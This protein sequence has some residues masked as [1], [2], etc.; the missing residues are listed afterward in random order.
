MSLAAAKDDGALLKN[1]VPLNALSDEQLGPLLS[2]ISVERAKKGTFLF[3]AG[4]RDEQNIYILSGHVTF[5]S[6]GREVD[7]VRSDSETARYPLAHK[8]PRQLSARAKTAVTFVR[9]DSRMLSDLL[10]R[11]QADEREL[12]D[13]DS[14]SGDWMSQLLQSPIFQQIPPAN[15]QQVMMRMETIEASAGDVIIRQNDKGDYYY[16]ISRGTCIVTRQP[17]QNSTPV[18]LAQLGPGNSFGEE[19][20]VSQMP[21]S[22]T[23]TMQTDGELVRLGKE[24]FENLVCTPLSRPLKYKEALERIEAGARWIDI[25]LPEEYE[26]L[27]LDEAIN[28]PSFSLR[29]QT[30]NLASNLEYIVYSKKPSFAAATAFLLLE[31][32]FSVYYLDEMLSKFLKKPSVTNIETPSVDKNGV[33]RPESTQKSVNEEYKKRL[34]QEQI[35]LQQ[36][37]KLLLKT[38]QS[39]A[40]AAD[41]KSKVT[42]QL[43][44][45]KSELEQAQS[46][47]TV[48][49]AVADERDQAV[50][51]IETLHASREAAEKSYLQQEGKLKEQIT[52][53]QLELDEAGEAN[54]TQLS[55]SAAAKKSIAKLEQQ[56]EQAQQSLQ[57]GKEQQKEQIATLQQQLA[58]LSDAGADLDSE[59][60]LQ[61]KHIEQLTHELASFREKQRADSA[62]QKQQQEQQKSESEQ[63]E[64]AYEEL[65]LKRDKLE[66]EAQKQNQHIELLEQQIEHSAAANT[67]FDEEKIELQQLIT[68]L[69]DE[70]CKLTE[71]HEQ[72]NSAHQNA[73]AESQHQTDSTNDELQKRS[74]Q[75]NEMESGFSQ[76][77]QQ[78]ERLNSTGASQDD[79][80]NALQTQT[81]TLSSELERLQDQLKSEESARLDEQAAHQE[82]L[83]QL[84]SKLQLEQDSTATLDQLKDSFKTEKTALDQQIKT[85]QQQL[86]DVSSVEAHHDLERDEQQQCISALNDKLADHLNQIEALEDKLK[87]AAEEQDNSLHAFQET[88]DE[89]VEKKDTFKADSKQLEQQLKQLTTEHNE[90]SRVVQELTRQLEKQGTE[91][92]QQ[93]TSSL[94]L[95]QRVDEL[96]VNEQLLLASLQDELKQSQCEIESISTERDA[97][98]QKADTAQGEVQQLRSVMEQYVDQIKSAQAGGDNA[99]ELE[100]LQ[101]ELETVRIQA[102]HDLKKLALRRT[103]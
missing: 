8:F 96:E 47:L 100:A 67:G 23:V 19:S 41:E 93:Q 18:K 95:Q 103:V 11:T 65:E 5:I 91:S 79:E 71:Q 53:L 36:L 68:S 27:H 61:Q 82:Q 54:N 30:F 49:D 20:L 101:S 15:M 7:A 12:T 84:Q 39:L 73:L 43:K 85:L 9:I 29:F 51:E 60:S 2:R 21:R 89:L 38:R 77:E 59:K 76:L 16:M 64:T 74:Q 56:L 3:E 6:D 72:Q 17:D 97:A 87:E 83:E 75:L 92:E 33:P 28:L 99:E 46:Q 14:C 22:G 48:H 90:Q 69:N 88:I 94:V 81:E 102:A 13:A 80:N 55:E 78:I 35:K 44:T 32:G 66:A 50:A 62:E 1:L 58:E 42:E 37:E 40:T 25:R 70:I 98:L 4:D 34:K 52:I 10:L 24:D 26:K 45:L 57:S 86:D 31:R 63:A